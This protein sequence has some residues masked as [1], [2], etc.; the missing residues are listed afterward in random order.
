MEEKAFLF[1]AYQVNRSQKWDHLFLWDPVHCKCEE[2]G[3]DYESGDKM[4]AYV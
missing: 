1:S 2:L 4:L 3:R